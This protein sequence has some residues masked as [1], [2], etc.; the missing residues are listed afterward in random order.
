MNATLLDRLRTAGAL[1]ACARRV[2]KAAMEYEMAC[3]A[4]QGLALEVSAWCSKGAC[5]GLVPA[6]RTMKARIEDARG[7]ARD[8]CRGASCIAEAVTHETL[9]AMTPDE[10][11]EFGDAVIRV[12][13]REA[14]ERLDEEVTLLQSLEHRGSALPVNISPTSRADRTASSL[15]QRFLIFPVIYRL[16]MPIIV[17]ILR[18]FL[19]LS[20]CAVC[21]RALLTR[22]LDSTK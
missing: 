13:S 18:S 11:E 15:W 3:D 2:D 16:R 19:L 5:A 10:R 20:Y 22:C 14:F 6:F 7:F 4:C 17:R 1:Q 8:L 12:M 21:I 9:V